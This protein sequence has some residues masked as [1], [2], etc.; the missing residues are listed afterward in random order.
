[1]GYRTFSESQ[2]QFLHDQA[3]IQLDA[4]SPFIA[5]QAWDEGYRSGLHAMEFYSMQANP[6]RKQGEQ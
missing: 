6:Y 4:A 3:R 5:A 1:M 2:K